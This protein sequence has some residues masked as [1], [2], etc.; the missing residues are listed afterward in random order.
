MIP[1]NQIPPSNIKGSRGRPIKR[2]GSTG[3]RDALR[4]YDV[5]LKERVRARNLDHRIAKQ[6]AEASA[7]PTGSTQ[8][9]TGTLLA[10]R[11]GLFREMEQAGP[12]GISQA[13][14]DRGRALGVADQDFNSAAERV[15]RNAS[16]TPGYRNPPVVPA[17]ST[18]ATSGV[19]TQKPTTAA[20]TSI[21]AT[22][23]L[24]GQSATIQ[25][26]PAPTINKLTG[27]PMGTVK[28]DSDYTPNWRNATAYADDA[29]AG[30]P[31]PP[32]PVSD[33]ARQAMQIQK[34]GKELVG[35]RDDVKAGIGRADAI[36]TPASRNILTS[37]NPETPV[38]RAISGKP[39]WRKS[40]M[41]AT[42][43]VPDRGEEK[44]LSVS[45]VMPPSPVPSSPVMPNRPSGPVM[46]TA[47]DSL[48]RN[49]AERA[50]QA[51]QSI[52]ER[53]KRNEAKKRPL[54]YRESSDN[55]TA[56]LGQQL[57]NTGTKILNF[58]EK[59]RL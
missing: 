47:A 18:S 10:D 25:G 32:E 31:K 46:T 42:A 24:P 20:K 53:D 13:M 22:P 19:S 14:R 23:A 30:T 50:K 52:Q 4:G 9:A 55:Y 39:A 2:Q 57:K 11:Q 6:E 58:M 45:P 29:K 54:P 40:P 5:P 17:A 44:Q 12:Q 56:P 27:M 59:E 21:P 1:D 28:G 33:L 16:F 38:Q 49:Q 7:S 3:F 48:Q 51:N 35:L 8:P 26:P 41:D 37:P 34:T 36:K 15:G 43:V